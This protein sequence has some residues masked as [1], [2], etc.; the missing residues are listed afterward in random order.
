MQPHFPRH[1]EDLKT[2]LAS[3]S[4]FLIAVSVFQLYVVCELRFLSK[5]GRTGRTRM[6][7]P[8]VDSLHVTPKKIFR[9]QNAITKSARKSALVVL[10]SEMYLQS[11]LAGEGL[12]A[13]VASES[14]S[15]VDALPVDI[16]GANGGEGLRAGFTSRFFAL[17]CGG[18]VTFQIFRLERLSAKGTHLFLERTTLMFDED[19]LTKVT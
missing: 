2:F 1:D 5:R 19:M 7:Y 17:V 6:P 10:L 9:L 8:L 3:L 15:A 13:I 14:S 4:P 18:D 16:E 12:V 11:I